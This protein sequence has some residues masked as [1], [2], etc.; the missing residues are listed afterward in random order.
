MSAGRGVASAQWGS[1]ASAEPKDLRVLLVAASLCLAPAAMGL[2]VDRVLDLK[3]GDLHFEKIRFTLGAEVQPPDLA[4]AELL[5]AGEMLVTPKRAG[6]GLLLLYKQGEVEAVRLHVDHAVA[7]PALD[8]REARHVCGAA[9]P[10]VIDG[11]TYLYA[12]VDGEACRAALLRALEGDALLADHLRLIFTVPGLQ[13]QLRTLKARLD[14]AGI[15]NLQLAYA[16]ATLTLTG[17]ADPATHTRALAILW[18]E[19]LGPL[20]LDDQTEIAPAS[21]AASSPDGPHAP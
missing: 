9:E 3:T 19:A 16:G 18:R 8:L 11:E 17:S 13:A 5:P 6:D 10:R 1:A 7:A 12:T 2:P 4:T 15:G 21:P 20:D 14:A